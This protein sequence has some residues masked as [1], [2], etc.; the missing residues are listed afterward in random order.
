MLNSVLIVDDWDNNSNQKKKKEGRKE[1]E[2]DNIRFCVVVAKKNRPLTL[3][4]KIIYCTYPNN[5]YDIK[6]QSYYYLEK[7]LMSILFVEMIA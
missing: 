7:D 4:L 2:Y 3:L 6:N 5:N 1:G